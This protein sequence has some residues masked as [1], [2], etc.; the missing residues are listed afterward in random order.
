MKQKTMIKHSRIINS[1]HIHSSKQLLIASRV[2][3]TSDC[4]TISYIN[5]VIKC[6]NVI[7]YYI[8]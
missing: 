6:T 3:F 5:E 4:V 7:F 8:M 1:K 2:K